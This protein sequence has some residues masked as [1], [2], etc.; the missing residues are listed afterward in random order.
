V[1]EAFRTALK[2]LMN[3][4]TIRD[5]R[6]PSRHPW[7]WCAFVLSDILIAKLPI[8]RPKSGV[9]VILVNRL[10]DAIVGRSLVLALQSSVAKGQPFL[11]LGDR[12]WEVLKD[13]IYND[14]ATK[15]IDE[16][17]FRT[18]ITYRIRISLWLRLQN[19]HTAICFMH[20]RL[21]MRDDA[22]VY[23]SAGQEK[24]VSELPFLNL[25]WYPWAFD[26]YLSKMTQIIPALPPLTAQSTSVDVYCKYKRKVPH[27]FERMR[28]FFN[29]LYPG[30]NLEVKPIVIP[31]DSQLFADQIVILNPGAKHEA[32]M[33]PLAEWVSLAYQITNSGYTVC[34]TGGPAEAHLIGEL[35]SL[36][37]KGRASATRK[38]HIVVAINQLSFKSL[39]GLFSRAVCYIGPDTGT[40]HLAYWL[41]TPTI[42]LLLHNAGTEEGD[43]FGDFFPYPEIFLP[44][45]YRCVCA[46]KAKF[47]MRDG[48]AGI[49]M[50]VSA[51][52]NELI[53][54]RSYV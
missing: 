38:A 4:L 48:S 40:S 46:T 16:Q 51:A 29:H 19:Y 54:V 12:S 50:E 35:R 44:T 49:R 47:H 30:A 28:D 25:R 13:N 53:E 3:N 20:H 9:V 11:V 27:A 5:P 31:T 41:G 15:Y 1:Y 42:T 43:R 21:E 37:E 39:I 8:P 33:W 45:P 52:F 24:I 32:R 7:K 10:G 17:R 2:F 26:F 22:L 6:S 23:V 18:D 14:I 36:I 34:F